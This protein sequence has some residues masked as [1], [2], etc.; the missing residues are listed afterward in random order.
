VEEPKVAVCLLPGTEVVFER[1]VRRYW[2][3]LPEGSLEPGYTGVRPKIYREGEPAADFAQ[4]LVREYGV[5][6]IPL[7]AFYHD[8]TDHRVIRFCFAKRDETLRAAAERLVRLR[9]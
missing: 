2:P 5:A 3:G 7:S 4:R 6:T 9:P 8:G 1:E